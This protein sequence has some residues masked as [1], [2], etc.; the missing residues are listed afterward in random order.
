MGFGEADDP[1]WIFECLKP[2]EVL[3]EEPSD[4]EVAFEDVFA[5]PGVDSDGPKCAAGG[6]GGER[7]GALCGIGLVLRVT[8]SGECA[9]GDRKSRPAWCWTHSARAQWAPLCVSAPPDEED[10]KEDEDAD[11]VLIGPT[12]GAFCAWCRC[13][14]PVHDQ[15]NPCNIARPQ[16][17]CRAADAARALRLQHQSECERVGGAPPLQHRTAPHPPLQHRTAQRQ[18]GPRPCPSGPR[19]CVVTVPAIRPRARVNTIGIHREQAAGEQNGTMGLCHQP[20]LA[21]L[22]KLLLLCLRSG[23]NHRTSCAYDA[24][25]RATVL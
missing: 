2:E 3:I 4:D 24:S 25:P 10:A 21:V 6:G 5:Q 20:Q 1:P 23:G 15:R 14:R 18:G 8:R 13:I 19:V 16:R 7:E 17:N 12:R 11:V 22:P 9:G